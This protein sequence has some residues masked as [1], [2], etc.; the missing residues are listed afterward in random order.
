MYVYDE[1]KKEEKQNA[2]IQQPSQELSATDNV[3]D[4][5]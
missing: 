3:T 5:P 2:R 1:K 4:V